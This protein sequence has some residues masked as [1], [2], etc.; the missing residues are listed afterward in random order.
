MT[1]TTQVRTERR[2]GRGRPATAGIPARLLPVVAALLVGAARCAGGAAG[3]GDVLVIAHGENVDLASHLAAGKHTVFDFYAAWCPPCRKLSPA[4]ERLAARHPDRL[5]IRKIDIVDW[6]MPVAA[7][8]GVVSLP[9]L[10]LYDAQG[11]RVAE[12]D[13]VFP[14]LQGLFG[15]A[16]AEVS[17]FAGLTETPAPPATM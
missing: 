5:A 17:A 11:T 16:A 12:G 13:N 10:I 2:P 3:P 8:H 6:T 1:D 15:D 4:L 14:A 7:Q 9:H